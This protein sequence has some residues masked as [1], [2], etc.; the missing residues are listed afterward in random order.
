MAGINITIRNG[1]SLVLNKIVYQVFKS[2]QIN[3]LVTFISS[4]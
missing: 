1:H 2:V 3:L 4:S